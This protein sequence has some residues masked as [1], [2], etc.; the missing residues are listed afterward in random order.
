[1]NASGNAVGG[2]ARANS[3]IRAGKV[4]LDVEGNVKRQ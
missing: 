1:M 2:I 4:E 3:T